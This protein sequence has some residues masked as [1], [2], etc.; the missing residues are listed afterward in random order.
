MTVKR[1]LLGVM[2]AG[3]VCG[4]A[5][6]QP[7]T[8]PPPP[9]SDGAGQLPNGVTPPYV[10]GPPAAPGPLTTLTAPP[11]PAVVAQPT[12]GLPGVGTA[13]VLWSGGSPAGC[14]GPVGANGPVTYEVYLRTGPSI[15]VG[16]GPEFSGALKD[17]WMVAGGGRT[18]YFNP[19]GDAAWA[20][21]LGLSYTYTRGAG[22]ER[23]IGVGTTPAANNN[24]NS[25]D[26]GRVVDPEQINAFNIRG[27]H[28]TSFNFAVGRDYWL[29]GPGNVACD[30]GWNTRVGWDVGGRW[31]TSHVDLVPVNNQAQYFRRTAIF[32]GMFLGLN[33]TKEIPMG[34]WIGFIGG[35]FEY[36]Y[37]W[38]NV[39]PPQ[40]GDL[41]SV[42]LLLSLG[43][44]F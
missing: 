38:G 29:N 19:A 8:M 41:Q 43:V 13:G 35:R 27:Y 15:T 10:G 39:V 1:F 18:L 22:A 6:A 9:M 20:L 16:G 42:N 24:P 44:R 32:H 4:G 40:D 12:T 34:S 11:G 7:P 23:V 21:D 37:D 31:G 30:G 25:P 33:W 26:F 5:A 14:C 36:S 2:T 28:R 3:A 17:G